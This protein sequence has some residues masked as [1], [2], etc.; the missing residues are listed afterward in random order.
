MSLS[1]LL[2]LIITYRTPLAIITIGAILYCSIIKYV[3]KLS[4][5]QV[6]VMFF[7]G[8][9]V[10]T[11]IFLPFNWSLNNS[12]QAREVSLFFFSLDIQGSNFIAILKNLIDQNQYIHQIEQL[13]SRYSDA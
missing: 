9:I 13:F 1:E 6:L 8:I 10:I 11:C 12:G 7:T 3:G 4:T 2:S 5:K